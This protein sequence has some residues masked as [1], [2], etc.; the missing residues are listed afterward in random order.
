MVPGTVNELSEHDRLILDI[1]KTSPSHIER[2]S[3]CERIGLP[4]GR[5]SGV[6]EGLADTDAAYGY[7]PFVVERVRRLRSERFAFERRQR[8]WQRLLH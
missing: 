7:A 2:E 1:E 8:R 5:Y 4:I 6:L 3:L